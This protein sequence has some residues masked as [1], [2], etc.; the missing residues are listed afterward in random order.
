MNPSMIV[1]G[2][3]LVVIVLV[4]IKVAPDIARYLRM[5]RM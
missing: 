2:V 4:L 3:L 1:I 5:R